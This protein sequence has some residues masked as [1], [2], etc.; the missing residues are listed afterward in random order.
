MQL[1]KA[2]GIKYPIHSQSNILTYLKR[3]TP[4]QLLH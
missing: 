2:L 1:K 4:S 3:I